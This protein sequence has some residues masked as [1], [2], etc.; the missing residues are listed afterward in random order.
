MG[1]SK[2]YKRGPK[3]KGETVPADGSKMGKGELKNLG[4]NKGNSGID[5]SDRGSRKY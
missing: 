5:P 3:G 1:S 2:S 4:N